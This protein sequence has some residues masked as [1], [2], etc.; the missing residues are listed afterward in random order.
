MSQPLMDYRVVTSGRVLEGYDPQVVTRAFASLVQLAPEQ[1]Q[2]YFSGKPR[3]V[4]RRTDQRTAAKYQHAFKRI[5]VDTTVVQIA[6]VAGAPRKPDLTLVA[7]DVEQAA[8]PTF[9]QRVQESA[10]SRATR[11]RKPAPAGSGRIRRA[12]E[13]LT[14]LGIIVLLGA[15][16]W[17]VGPLAFS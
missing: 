2:L 5:G 9:E 16:V 7:G 4:Q 17:S 6:P 8:E 12:L 3:V 10:E 11:D 1:A 15:F 14:L 13:N